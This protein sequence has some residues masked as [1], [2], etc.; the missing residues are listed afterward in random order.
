V[1]V[2][3]FPSLLSRGALLLRGP[4]LLVGFL[5]GFAEGTLFFIIPDLLIT[6]VALFSFKQ[7]LKQL[8]V[9]LA[10]SLLGGWLLFSLATRD[11]TAI[12]RA[13]DGVPFVT[14]RMFE[15]TQRNY[16][17]SG[18]WTLGQGPLSGIP[19]KVFAVEAPGHAPLLSFL[20]ASIP[21]RLERLVLP[22]ALFAAAGLWLKKRIAKRPVWVVA[23]HAIFWI[24]IYAYYWSVVR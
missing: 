10:G 13:V 19:Y 20:L 7:S 3:K 24:A 15:A 17:T 14:P 23:A 22:W 11:Y 16:E 6:F 1:S 2:G 12:R 5:W 18:L 8:G 9:V 4:G 21:G